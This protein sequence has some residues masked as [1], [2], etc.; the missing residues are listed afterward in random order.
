[1]V[2]YNYQNGDM[3]AGSVPANTWFHFG[4]T[5]AGP[6]NT[7]KIY[8]DGAFSKQSAAGESLRGHLGVQQHYG[9]I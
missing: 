4:L 2:G 8:I 6:G 1:M 3:T 5:W 9:A 7:F